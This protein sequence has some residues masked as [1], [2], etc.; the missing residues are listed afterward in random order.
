M[1][2]IS[3][4]TLL[5]GKH[6]ESLRWFLYPSEAQQVLLGKDTNTER[7]FVPPFVPRRHGDSSVVICQD[8]TNENNVS[9]RKALGDKFS[10]NGQ[11]TITDPVQNKSDE[12]KCN[13]CVGKITLFLTIFDTMY[14]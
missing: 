4:Q 11:Q 14:M 6:G 7:V 12:K 10:S 3:D 13:A 9:V 1:P 2:L 8:Y 5:F